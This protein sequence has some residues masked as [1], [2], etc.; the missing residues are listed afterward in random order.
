MSDYDKPG[1]LRMGHISQLLLCLYGARFSYVAIRNLRMYEESTKKA[2]KWSKVVEDH[3][4]LTR[5]TQATAALTVRLV[6][7]PPPSVHLSNLCA[8]QLIASGVSAIVMI[9]IP[10]YI[11]LGLQLAISPLMLVGILFARNHVR[12]YWAPYKNSKG[13][14]VSTRVPLPLM[15]EYNEAEEMTERLLEVLQYLEYSWLATSVCL[16]IGFRY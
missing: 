7:F 1:A 15:E 14:D 10:Q 4:F 3:L 12:K 13:K 9:A 8:S 16:G 6:P 2:A 11:P 5:T